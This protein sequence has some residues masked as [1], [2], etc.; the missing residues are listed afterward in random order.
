MP[1][2][3]S[4]QTHELAL[5]RFCY[6]GNMTKPEKFW[7]KWY[8]DRQAAWS[9]QVNPTLAKYV[10]TLPHSKH[11]RA[12]DLGCGEGADAIWLA[13]HGWRVTAV[14]VSSI[15]LKR[16][17]KLAQNNNVADSVAFELR[18][19]G[20]SLPAGKFDLVSAQFLHSQVDFPREEI[21]HKVAGLV[22]TSGILL[23]VGHAAPPPWSN[24]H[25]EIF[26]S[27]KEAYEGI[28]LNE[29]SWQVLTLGD[30]D[31][32]TLDPSGKPAKMCDSIIQLKR[33]Q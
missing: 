12:L 3:V 28:G 23:I 16:A 31:R 11:A 4:S 17:K 10:E 9:G 18:N 1:A 13:K 24:H 26:K 14:D 8:Q 30:F 7:D 15:A 21:L 2:N 22:A 5:R 20:K 32:E 19:L 6:H 33:L 25:H 27:A 29:T